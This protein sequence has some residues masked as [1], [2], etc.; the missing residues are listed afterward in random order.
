MLQVPETVSF[1]RHVVTPPEAAGPAASA[2]FER[3]WRLAIEIE[4][5]V[6]TPEG[7]PLDGSRYESQVA[8]SL[9][10]SLIDELEPLLRR[11]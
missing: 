11:R 6:S 9:A 5:L 7:R 2:R 1:D 8:L 10:R 3:A 4:A